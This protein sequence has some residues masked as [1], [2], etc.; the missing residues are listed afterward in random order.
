MP[1]PPPAGHRLPKSGVRPGDYHGAASRHLMEI[2]DSPRQHLR[3]VATARVG[4][5]RAARTPIALGR[6]HA[7]D[8]K[9]APC[10]RQ[11]YGDQSMTWNNPNSWIASTS[12]RKL[13]AS[14]LMYG[15]SLSVR[16]SSAAGNDA[17]ASI[18][19]NRA[20][21]FTAFV[22]TRD[23]VQVFYKDWGPKSAQPIVF[24]HG[25]PLSSD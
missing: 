10:P 17:D 16:S 5:N 11:R 19:A 23:G 3:E 4:S 18:S 7:P 25:W 13:L 21:D 24:H 14:A 1:R 9:S 12:R 6:R 2:H 22:T 20:T 8:A 15:V